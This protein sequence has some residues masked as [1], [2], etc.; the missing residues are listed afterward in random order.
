MKYN[1]FFILVFFCI[2]ELNA[3]KLR[4]KNSINQS[5]QSG[6]S[7]RQSGNS[8]PGMKLSGIGK[9][10]SRRPS[11]G[12]PSSGR[13]I[14]EKPTI[15]QPSSGNSTREESRI[16]HPRC[17]GIRGYTK[18]QLEILARISKRME[19]GRP[20]E[21][22]TER[23][24]GIKGRPTSRPIS[25]RGQGSIPTKNI[26]QDKVQKI[27]KFATSKKD[28]GCGYAYGSEGQ[29][30]TPDL[31][32]NLKDKYGKNVKESTSKW[33]NKE[34]YDCSGLVMKALDQAGIKV[35]HSAKYTWTE[36]MKQRG[37]IKDIPNDKL[38]LVFRKG[39]DG[40][41]EHIGI[42]LGNGKVIEARGADYGVV[43]RDLK[44]GT[45]TNWGVPE[46][47]E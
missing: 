14:T 41:M 35:H 47:L 4:S 6:H 31:L 16:K 26:N 27:T 22:S 33:M 20:I 17:G 24:I 8:S 38:C 2:I 32:K 18:E 30:L 45:W 42:Y 19:T 44:E 29:T 23:L 40:Q 12:K 28:S 13:P 46:G 43:E 3:L 25:R 1:L 39:K 21:R 9:P 5:K 7:N 34:C 11:S 15:G 36:D 37:D 10:S